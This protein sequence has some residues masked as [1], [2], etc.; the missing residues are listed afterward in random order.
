[1]LGFRGWVRF[2]SPAT[3]AISF[4]FSSSGY[5]DVS[6]PPVASR[7]PMHSGRGCWAWP[8]AAPHSGTPGSK[9]VCASPGL[10][11]ACRALRRLPMPRHP[12]CALSILPSEEGACPPGTC[13][14]RVNSPV[15]IEIDMQQKKVS[16]REYRRP[17][18]NPYVWFPKS[19]E[20]Y[21]PSRCDH[22]KRKPEGKT[23]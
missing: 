9:A 4:D 2:R 5:L 1:M 12:P 10:I 23:L 16:V 17:I 22:P 7:R 19:I 18:G 21:S 6:V 3:R 14:L 8:Q 15:A 13:F 11:A 20:C